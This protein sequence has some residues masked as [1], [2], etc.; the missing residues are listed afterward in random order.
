MH[1]ET[2]K[3]HMQGEFFAGYELGLSQRNL[4]PSNAKEYFRLGWSMG[5]VEAEGWLREL[6]LREK[7]RQFF[8]HVKADLRNSIRRLRTKKIRAVEAAF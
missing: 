8:R 6:W 4:P 2:W 5:H 3:E 1:V 7:I